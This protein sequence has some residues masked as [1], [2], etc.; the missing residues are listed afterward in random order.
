LVIHIVL[1][2]LHYKRLLLPGDAWDYTIFANLGHFAWGIGLGYL[3]AERK[4]FAFFTHPLS[5]VA[6]L[7]IAYAGKML[8]YSH[9][10]SALHGAGF[11]AETIGPLMMTM[12]F[13]CMIYS[14]LSSITLSKI[15]GARYI[16][17]LGTITYSFYLWYN[18]ILLL[19]YTQVGAH[20]P[21]TALGLTLLLLLVLII[22]IPVSLLSYRLFE[23]FYFKPRKLA[24][25]PGRT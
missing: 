20:I 23:S 17:A 16:A 14:T 8:F 5:I 1:N 9:V 18:F 7:V 6:G 25:A 12:G 3:Y 19:V 21:K 15:F 11:I 24:V 22:L 10:V 2:L 13:A 4:Q